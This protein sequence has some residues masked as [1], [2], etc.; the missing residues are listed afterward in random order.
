MAID[1]MWFPSSQLHR[2]MILTPEISW[3]HLESTLAIA[4]GGEILA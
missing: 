4:I 2:F 3:P 1:M